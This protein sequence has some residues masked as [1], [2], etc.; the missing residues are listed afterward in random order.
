MRAELSK[1]GASR[2]Q[3]EVLVN[4]EQ[5]SLSCGYPTGILGQRA[6]HVGTAVG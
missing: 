2:I 1:Q 3:L 6:R 4:N 5:A